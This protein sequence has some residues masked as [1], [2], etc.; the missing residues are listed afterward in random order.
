MGLKGK[1]VSEFPNENELKNNITQKK[2][3]TLKIVIIVILSILLVFLI[4]VGIDQWIFGNSFPSFITNEAWAS[5]LGSY[6]GG[7]C[8]MAAVFINIKYSNYTLDLQK[9]DQEKKELEMKKTSIRPYLDTRQTVFNEETKMGPNDRYVQME[10]DRTITII[11]SMNDALSDSIKR[12]LASEK[13]SKQF[14]NYTIRNVGAG[15][16]VDMFVSINNHKDQIAIAKD[17]TVHILLE[18][19]LRNK[20]EF[21]I[22]IQLEY[23]D[24]ENCAHYRKTES[25][26]YYENH[27]KTMVY[28]FIKG[29]QKEV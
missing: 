27:N 4:P 13:S 23:S 28:D 25:F 18:I 2:K 3:G 22:N 9:K 11:Y 20:K 16:A 26:R 17:E 19:N 10:D 15:S 5:F 24:I 8:T 29:E 7:I 1:K 21:Y 6:I 14:V 12:A